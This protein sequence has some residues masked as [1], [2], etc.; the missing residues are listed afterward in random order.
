MQA[1]WPES[2]HWSHWLQKLVLGAHHVA[3]Q[4]FGAVL[5]PTDRDI[6]SNQLLKQFPLIDAATLLVVQREIRLC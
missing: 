6:G 4:L 2:L 5:L 3:A 1:G